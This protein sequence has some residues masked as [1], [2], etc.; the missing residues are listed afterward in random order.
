MSK[1]PSRTYSRYSR[2]AA[3]LLGQMIRLRRIERK[4]TAQE[5]ADRAGISRALLQ[6]VE[7]GDLSCSIG[8]VF[9]TAALLGVP[10]FELD[11]AGLTARI[12]WN[13]DKLTLLPKSVRK[14]SNALK[15][16]F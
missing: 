6:R 10:L 14:S 12:A 7:A 4:L 2:E 15:D 11:K 1:P 16:D 9:E 8:A 3:S 5:L 13:K